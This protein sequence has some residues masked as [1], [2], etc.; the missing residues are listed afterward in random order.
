MLRDAKVLVAT[1]IH[2]RTF[3]SN[4]SR[5]R[6]IQNASL[7][8]GWTG[9]GAGNVPIAFELL[10]CEND[11]VAGYLQAGKRP[12]HG[13]HQRAAIV[14]H[15]ADHQ[16]V[17][18]AAIAAGPPCLRSEQNHAPRLEPFHESASGFGQ[19]GLSNHIQDSGVGRVIDPPDLVTA[20][21]KR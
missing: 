3:A 12:V 21:N 11:D 20:G 2:S 15:F 8:G 4:T 19:Y 9:D 16:Q 1:A 13:H 17:Y 7:L 10:G 5:G 6:V 18:I 14:A